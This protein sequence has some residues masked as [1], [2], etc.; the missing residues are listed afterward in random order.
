MPDIEVE[1]AEPADQE[2]ADLDG[3]DA[4]DAL[5]ESAFDEDDECGAEEREKFAATLTVRTDNVSRD[6][7]FDLVRRKG[8][9][10]KFVS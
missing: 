8:S 6:S 7:M 3:D 4:I 1:Q 9:K 2:N 10:I 5:F